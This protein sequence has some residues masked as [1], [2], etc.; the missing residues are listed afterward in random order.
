MARR[1]R[2][3][4]ENFCPCKSG[5]FLVPER[6]QKRDRVMFLIVPIQLATL[7]KQHMGLSHD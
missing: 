4:P 1:M 6:E 3:D 5:I 2:A 7:I